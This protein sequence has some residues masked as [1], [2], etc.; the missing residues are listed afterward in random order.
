M[1]DLATIRCELCGEP[2]GG[3]GT[4]GYIVG[5]EVYFCT[6]SLANPETTDIIGMVEAHA[7]IHNLPTTTE[8]AA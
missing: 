4:W 1:T 2:I 3:E 7:G 5:H 8:E 6:E